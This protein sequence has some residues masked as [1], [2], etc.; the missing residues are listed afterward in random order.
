M[1]FPGP[2]LFKLGPVP[3]NTLG[4]A[5]GLAALIG[6]WMMTKAAKKEGIQADYIADLTVYAM[7]GG[8]L[9]ARLWYVVFMWK[10][11]VDNP[12]EIFM[13]WHGGLAIQGGILGGTLAG[14][15]LAKKRGL[16]AWRL[17]DIVAPA[18]ILGMAIG[19]IADFL[20]GDAYGTPSNSIFAVS[21][22]PGTYVYN[23]YGSVPILPM[24]LF[25]AIGDLIILGILL[26]IKN[27]KPFHGFLF[28]LMLA[29]Y[30]VSRFTMEFWRGDSLRTIFDL[31]VA[32]LTALAT[33]LI[34]VGILVLRFRQ[35]RSANKSENIKVGRTLG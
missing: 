23:V 5:V 19:R 1:W 24:P 7:I 32:Q 18:L 12:M 8:I 3:I 26:W 28:L 27:K 15:W 34:A 17:A 22:P 10:N 16:D 6:L 4:F 11:Y 14:I 13:V 25:E 2:V 31:K 29:L 35:T 9:G 30:S 21:Y 33:I 20:T